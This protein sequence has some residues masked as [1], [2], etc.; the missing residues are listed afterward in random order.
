MQ[1]KRNI[2]LIGVLA[3]LIIVTV[4][5][6]FFTQPAD[7]IK[8]DR[9]IFAYEDPS[10]IDKVILTKRNNSDT[11]AY[12]GSVWKVNELYDADAQRV[13]VIFAL[14]K[15]ER[16]RRKVARQKEDSLRLAFE[17][18][19]VQVNF[20][21]K[22]RLV[23]HFYVLGDDNSKV[24]YMA[25]SPEQ[26][27][28]IVEIPGYRSYLAGV[29]ELD[30][31]GWRNPRIFDFNWANLRGVEVQ[32]PQKREKGFKVGFEESFYQ[33]HSI[34]ET[35]SSKV[36]DFLDN[37]SLLYANDFLGHTEITKYKKEIIGPPQAVISVYEVGGKAYT[38]EV[39]EALPNNR[40]I[41]GR[42]DSIDYA[43]FDISRIR[44]ILKPK[45][46]F[47]KKEEPI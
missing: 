36:T 44:N 20:Y 27:A 16:V 28:Y 47:R 46:Y 32:Y 4:L 1:R 7:K 19:G 29:Y 35:D 13:S 10:G 37:V 39:Y 38:L 24:T 17:Q 23:K 8:V 34:A 33:V 6:Y 22:G 41:I 9:N 18:H 25:N 12:N 3:I 2:K 31:N 15:Q 30:V 21:E 40:E 11:L 26:Q 43:I 42:K 5:M 45:T 14:L